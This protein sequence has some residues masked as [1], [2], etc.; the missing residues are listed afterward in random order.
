MHWDEIEHVF[1]EINGLSLWSHIGHEHRWSKQRPRSECVTTSSKQTVDWNSF[2]EETKSVNL[3][4]TGKWKQIIVAQFG[5]AFSLSRAWGWKPHH[6][7]QAATQQKDVSD[8]VVPE[9]SPK[10][11]GACFLLCMHS[12][13]VHVVKTLQNAKNNSHENWEISGLLIEKNT[14]SFK[15][16]PTNAITAVCAKWEFSLSNIHVKDGVKNLAESPYKIS[17]Q[18]VSIQHLTQNLMKTKE[19]MFSASL[20]KILQQN[21]NS[22]FWSTSEIAW[23]CI[24]LFI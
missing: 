10:K 15:T 1:V 16:F 20:H 8:S 7:K 6:H 19:N 22:P 14:R 5:C 11:R 4:E 13:H 12:S 23:F 2:N 9:E 3:T 21:V 18:H 24:K 17:I